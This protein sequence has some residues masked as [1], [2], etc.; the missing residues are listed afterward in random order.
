MGATGFDGTRDRLNGMPRLRNLVN[1]AE[2]LI[3]ADYGQVAY[4]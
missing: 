4:A 2:H 3:S 1:Q